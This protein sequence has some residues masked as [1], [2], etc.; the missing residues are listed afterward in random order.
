MEPVRQVQILIKP[1][2]VHFSQMFL[3]K[4]SVISLAKQ[5]RFYALL[6]DQSINIHILKQ[7][8]WS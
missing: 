4:S 8:I 2:H 6:G 7:Q 5:I 1:I 3:V